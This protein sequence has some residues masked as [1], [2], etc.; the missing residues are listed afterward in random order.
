M[1]GHG[2]ELDEDLR[3][4]RT[5][6]GGVVVL[7]VSYIRNEVCTVVYVQAS[8]DG[9]TLPGDM[10]EHG[11]EL[12]QDLRRHLREHVTNDVQ[13]SRVVLFVSYI[14]KKGYAR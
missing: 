10:R 8:V 9:H 6:D 4:H 13:C 14:A 2:E 11:K 1:P 5:N 7:L 3:G 12:E